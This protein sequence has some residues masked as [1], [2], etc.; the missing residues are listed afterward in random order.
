MRQMR[1]ES[2]RRNS[3]D[4]GDH[5]NASFRL[6]IEG[7][8]AIAILLVVAAMDISRAGTMLWIP[9]VLVLGG[10]VFASLALVVA[11]QARS[12]DFFTYYFTLVLTPMTFLSGVYFPLTSLPVPL[13]WLAQVLPLHAA[14]ELVRPLL[15]GHFDAKAG[16][17]L[18]VLGADLLLAWWLARTLTQ[19]RFR[20]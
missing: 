10:L 5:R 8:R 14:V 12:Y 7:L 6:D 17:H 4:C 2:K 19:R 18:V 16:L 20:A 3:K 9:P 13:Q 15:F 1:A 11:V